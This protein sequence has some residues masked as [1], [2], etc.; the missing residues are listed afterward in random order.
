MTLLLMALPALLIVVAFYALTLAIAS[1]QDRDR[2]SAGQLH[3]IF[4]RE[5]QRQ[6]DGC[7]PPWE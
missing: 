6:L 1:H 7:A 2:L 4:R 5:H 3:D